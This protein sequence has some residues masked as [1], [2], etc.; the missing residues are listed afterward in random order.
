MSPETPSEAVAQGG[1]Q[2]LWVSISLSS[3][4]SRKGTLFMEREDSSW[5]LMGA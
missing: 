2:V 3:H 5:P 4:S 1:E